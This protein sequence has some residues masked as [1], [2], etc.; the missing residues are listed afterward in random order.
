MAAS[1]TPT[2]EELLAHAG[3][4]R[5][6]A[7]RLIADEE[8]A[9]DVVQQAWSLAIERPPA[10]GPRL[11]S[12]LAQLIRNL[13]RNR[14]R[15]DERRE[16][17]ERDAAREEATPSAIEVAA[18]LEAQQRIAAALL[19]VDEPYRETLVRRWVRDEKPAEIARAMGA[20]V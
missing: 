8:G 4:A 9:A 12:W 1:A 11:R 13:A 15:A 10:P 17:H 7:R 16:R 19:R 6:L 20:P 2:I 5:A 18:E 14:R 3:F